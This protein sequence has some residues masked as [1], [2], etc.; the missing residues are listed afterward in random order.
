MIAGILAQL[1]PTIF[2]VV[3]KLFGSKTGSTKMGA[4]INAVTPILEALAAAGRLSGPAP[5]QDDVRKI[6]EDLLR[7]E[8]AKPDWKE[9]GDL[10]FGGKVY[11]VFVIEEIK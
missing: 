10:S 4:T 1:A 8:K 6:L 7:V 5:Q 3:E 9:A 2:R 11:R